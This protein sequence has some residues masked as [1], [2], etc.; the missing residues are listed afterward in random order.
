VGI[1]VISCEACNPGVDSTSTDSSSDVMMYAVNVAFPGVKG[2][3]TQVIA[4]DDNKAA[5]ETWL[6]TEP[7]NKH[8]YRAAEVNPV[9]WSVT[10]VPPFSTRA[11]G[12][13]E[14]TLMDGTMVMCA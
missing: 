8:A 1:T 9:P 5:R 13:T 12:D 6:P 2:G 7:A 14:D 4:A 3:D 10:M 11:S